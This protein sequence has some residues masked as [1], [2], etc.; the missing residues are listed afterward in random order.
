MQHLKY[1]QH[2]KNQ[3]TKHENGNILKSSI[4][5]TEKFHCNIRKSFVATLKKTYCN[6]EKQQKKGV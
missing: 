2:H 1:L 4:A 6:K 3:T 5:T